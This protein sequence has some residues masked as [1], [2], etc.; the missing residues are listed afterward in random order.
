MSVLMMVELMVGSRV[1][2]QAE[3]KVEMKAGHLDDSTVASKVAKKV[4]RLDMKTAV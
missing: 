2:K 4:G 1:A 3:L